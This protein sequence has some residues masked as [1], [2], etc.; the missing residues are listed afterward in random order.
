[1]PYHQF[2]MVSMGKKTH[3]QSGYSIRQYDILTLSCFQLSQTHLHI[4]CRG[5]VTT[6]SQGIMHTGNGVDFLSHF[7]SHQA[8]AVL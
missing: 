6:E 8:P 1:M 3:Q 5:G 2:A 4:F 7:T